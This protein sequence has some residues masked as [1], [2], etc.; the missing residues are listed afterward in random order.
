MKVDDENGVLCKILSFRPPIM[1]QN[2]QTS[3]IFRD[4][5]INYPGSF[6][7][8]NQAKK[9]GLEKCNLEMGIGF[10]FL[11]HEIFKFKDQ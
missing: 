2:D 3:A 9:M 7:F 4:D 11:D 1:A 8:L 5:V 6:T 10:G